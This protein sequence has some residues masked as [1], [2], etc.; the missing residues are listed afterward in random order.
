MATPTCCTS[1]RSRGRI[2]HRMLEEV[3]EPDDT[4]RL[5]FGPAMKSCGCLPVAPM[6]KVPCSSDGDAAVTEA[7]AVRA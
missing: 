1:S 4:V 3:D 5:G 7:P 2:A 6:G